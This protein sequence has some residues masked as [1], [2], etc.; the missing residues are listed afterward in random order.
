[1]QSFD[2]IPASTCTCLI[3]YNFTI[4]LPDLFSKI[5]VQDCDCVFVRS[6][7]TRRK[8][9]RIDVKPHEGADEST[10]LSP[11]TC[12]KFNNEVK[13]KD[14]KSERKKKDIM[15]F[16]N[17]VTVVIII[18]HK[19]VNIKVC[20]N[21]VLQVTGCRDNYLPICSDVILDLIYT[22]N[23]K[24]KYNDETS[25][26]A[27]ALLVPAMRNIDFH[28]G[29]CIDREMLCDYIYK[30]SEIRCLPETLGHTGV[31]LKLRLGGE[32]ESLPVIS[33]SRKLMSTSGHL[34]TVTV[35][36]LPPPDSTLPIDYLPAHGKWTVYMEYLKRLPQREQLKK[37]KKQ[38]YNTFLVF[39][40]GKVIF[41]SLGALYGRKAYNELAAIL[42]DARSQVEWKLSDTTTE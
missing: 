16:K 40:T 25:E 19:P 7:I 10:P 11:V 17:S 30:R 38:R 6:D 13:G 9:I 42:T 15:W 24:I 34:S 31:N 33:L 28:L 22:Y 21:G 18:N 23:I 35:Q 14:H 26:V 27:E 20:S 5:P 4:D 1:M 2:S 36:G 3:V 32:L 29:Y 37:I 41:S 39:Q 12:M 8:Y